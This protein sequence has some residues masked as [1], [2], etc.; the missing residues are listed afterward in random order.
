MAD[1]LVI[2]KPDII[3]ATESVLDLVVAVDRLP[4]H[5]VSISEQGLSTTVV[6][7]PDIIVATEHRPDVVISIDEKQNHVVTVGEQGPPGA[8][9]IQ[10]ERGND[11]IGLPV[12]F[13]NLTANDVLKYTGTVWTNDPQLNLTDGGNF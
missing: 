8:Q 6:Q 1:N 3:V 5:A 11:G 10:G 9:G 7:K 12:S 4:N 2:Q 13:V